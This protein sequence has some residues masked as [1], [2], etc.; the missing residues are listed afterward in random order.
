[1]RG[2]R[3]LE[4]IKGRKSKDLDDDIDR[5]LSGASSALEL[6][7]DDD[8]GDVLGGSNDRR[9]SVGTLGAHDEEDEEDD[10]VDDDDAD[11]DD[12][13]PDNSGIAQAASKSA[14]PS[15]FSKPGQPLAW[16]GLAPIKRADEKL[17]KLEDEDDDEQEP[18][19]KLS[20]VNNPAS[21]LH[22]APALDTG[23]LTAPKKTPEKPTDDNEDLDEVEED[24]EEDFELELANSTDDDEADQDL[25]DDDDP[26]S[27]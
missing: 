24:I 5:L 6:L 20:T 12:G 25:D 17:G 3:T 27:F 2:K 23:S 19:A 9:K 21:G 16:G 13:I 4:S 14:L 11:D 22:Q 7:G 15:A 8:E 10:V 1:M 26:G 18:T